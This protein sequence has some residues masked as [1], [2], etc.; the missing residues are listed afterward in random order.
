MPPP[1][2]FT[3]F[4]FSSLLSSSQLTLELGD[5]ELL[6][7][8]ASAQLLLQF[9]FL[10]FAFA[11]GSLSVYAPVGAPTAKPPRVGRIMDTESRHRPWHELPILGADVW[12]VELRTRALRYRFA[13]SLSAHRPSQLAELGGDLAAKLRL[14]PRGTVKLILTTRVRYLDAPPGAHAP[15]SD[16]DGF[17]EAVT[18]GASSLPGDRDR[19]LSGRGRRPAS[20]GQAAESERSPWARSALSQAVGW[21][22]VIAPRVGSSASIQLDMATFNDLCTPSAL[23]RGHAMATALEFGALELIYHQV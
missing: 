20:Q 17:A 2:L 13:D 15:L 8:T 12:H 11:F 7:D 23:E 10:C 6:W 1:L 5:T 19:A 4:R 18:D 9:L 14:T 3:S 22:C 16:A 21:H